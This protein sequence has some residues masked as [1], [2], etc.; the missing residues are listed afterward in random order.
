LDVSFSDF[1]EI[2]FELAGFYRITKGAHA[3]DGLG[4]LRYT[5]MDVE[6]DLPGQPPDADGRKD[7]VDCFIGLRSKW[8]FRLCF[9]F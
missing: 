4:G 6:F 3:I 1:T 2:L 7:R 9:G 5:S 8:R